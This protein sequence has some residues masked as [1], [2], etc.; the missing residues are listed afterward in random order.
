MKRLEVS[1]AVRP[2]YASLDFQGLIRSVFCALSS[3]IKF[4]KEP[5]NASEFMNENLLH[6]NQRHVL[7]THVSIFRVMRKRIQIHL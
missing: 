3:R 5:T 6:S 4:L 7:A 2:I 1:G